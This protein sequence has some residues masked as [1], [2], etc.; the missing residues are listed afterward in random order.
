MLLPNRC[1]LCMRKTIKPFGHN[2]N[3]LFW[4]GAGKSEPAG[5]RLCR[6]RPAAALGIRTGVLIYSPTQ[7]NLLRLVGDDTAAVRKRTFISLMQVL[8]HRFSAIVDTE[9]FKDSLQV[10]V[11]SPGAD[12]KQVRDFL[13]G[14]ALA[15][16]GE[17]FVLA[18][19]QSD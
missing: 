8:Q 13:V 1:A 4:G 11:N 5:P 2:Y 14:L 15:E 17:D 18:V 7:I 6:P 19:G 10:T 3:A 16:Q 9:F 12:V